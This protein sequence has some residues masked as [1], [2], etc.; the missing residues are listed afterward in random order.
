M[1]PCYCSTKE[2]EPELTPIRGLENQAVCTFTPHI[3]HL[4]TGAMMRDLAVEQC[5][6]VYP[7]QDGSALN[8][9]TREES[10][11]FHTTTWEKEWIMP[12]NA[13]CHSCLVS[14]YTILIT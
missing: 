9:P 13:Y 7:E 4:Y 12:Q 14:V 11:E 2:G 6:M 1:S 5:H 8:Q 3:L 10:S